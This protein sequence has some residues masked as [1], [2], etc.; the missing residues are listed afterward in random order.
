MAHAYT[1][2][3]Q[4]TPHTILRKERILPLKGEVLVK[5]GDK[6]N[7]TDIVA[8]TELPGDVDIVNMAYEL[9]SDPKEMKAKMTVDEGDPIE[10]GQAIG[11]TSSFFGLFKHQV[12]AP[13]DGTIETI[14][15][16]TGKVLIRRPPL[17]VEV[18]AYID[19]TVVDVRPEEG[20]TV[21]SPA[22]FIQGIIGVGGEV[23]GPL[24][25]VVDSANDMLSPDLIGEDCADAVVV[26]GRLVTAEALKRAQEVGVAA[27]V[28]GGIHDVD[29]EGY[30]G[31]ALG[32]AITGH[33]ELGTTVVVTEGFGE[34]QM[35]DRTFQ[36]LKDHEGDL[37]SCNGATQIRAG[38]IRPEV[39]IPLKGEAEEV[40][41]A[42]GSMAVGDTVRIIREP[43]FGILAEVTALP[44]ELI[45][46]PT[47]AKVRA[48][49]VRLPDGSDLT[50]PRANVEVIVS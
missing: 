11:K 49:T 36:L 46:V 18:T 19:G 7:G 22:A 23:Q 30:L 5:E 33:E 25:I 34:I 47:E 28:V 13:N 43:N 37:A 42:D 20:V 3:L 38:V 10:A 6:V 4:V 29:L 1:P 21:Q 17:P 9:G 26:G 41:E 45:A 2:G 50:L 16:V 40:E 24:K 12:N 32:V 15:E 44:H 27:V 39:A 35:A 31:Y 48:L 14:S 8:R